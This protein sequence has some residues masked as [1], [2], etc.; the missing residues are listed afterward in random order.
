MTVEA[1]RNERRARFVVQEGGLKFI[2]NL[3][4]YVDTGLFLDHRLTRQMVR[5]EP[6]VS[7]LVLAFMPLAK[8]LDDHR[9]VRV[10]GFERCHMAIAGR[11]ADRP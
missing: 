4:D 10:I 3:S 6:P 7:A 11:L 1:E 5:E 8:K 9:A 2:V